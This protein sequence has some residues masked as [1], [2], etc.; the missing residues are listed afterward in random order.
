MNLSLKIQFQ[1]AKAKAVSSYSQEMLAACQQ[2][3]ETLRLYSV[4]M[5]GHPDHPLIRRNL[6]NQSPA[7][8]M[9]ADLS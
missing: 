2:I 5:T 3:V 8:R 9:A 6:S 1:Q 7:C 4:L